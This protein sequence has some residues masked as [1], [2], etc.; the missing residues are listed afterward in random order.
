MKGAYERGYEAGKQGRTYFDCP[1]S[2]SH[3]RFD[4]GRWMQG[5]ADGMRDSSIHDEPEYGLGY[6]QRRGAA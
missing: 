6:M 5:H 1:Y 4:Y 2:P 3:H